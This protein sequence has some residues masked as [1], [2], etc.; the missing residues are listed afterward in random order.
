MADALGD[1]A[2]GN[3]AAGWSRRR[4][5]CDICHAT[6]VEVSRCMSSGKVY[7]RNN[8]ECKRA[9]GVNVNGTGEGAKKRPRGGGDSGSG[10]GGG[11]G[12]G[13]AS[14]N[15][16]GVTYDLEL[17]DVYQ[18]VGHRL[19]DADGLH[20][21]DARRGERLE[22]GSYDVEFYVRGIFKRA[23]AD[24]GLTD[25]LW[26][27]Q[28]EIQTL[29]RRDAATHERIT[30]LIIDYRAEMAMS[31]NALYEEE[32]EDEAPVGANAA[33]AAGA[34]ATGEAAA[35]D[36][37]DGAAVAAA[38][39]ASG[40]APH[41][42]L[43]RR[44]SQHIA[45]Q[46]C[47][48]SSIYNTFTNVSGSEFSIWLRHDSVNERRISASKEAAIDVQA[49]A[50]LDAAAAAAALLPAA[51]PTPAPAPPPTA[52]APPEESP[53]LP[54]SH[55]ADRCPVC[56]EGIS[57]WQCARCRQFA[58][59][60]CIATHAEAVRRK[61]CTCPLDYCTCKR[62]PSCPVCREP[63]PM[64]EGGVR[65]CGTPGCVLPDNHD[66]ACSTEAAS[67][68]RTR[69]GVVPLAGRSADEGGDHGGRAVAGSALG[70]GRPQE[71]CEAL[72]RRECAGLQ[73]AAS[74]DFV[75]AAPPRAHS[76][77]SAAVSLQPGT[78][79]HPPSRAARTGLHAQ[80]DG[81]LRRLLDGRDAQRRARAE[82]GGVQ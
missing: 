53:E 34:A 69:S 35:T 50:Y 13:S 64:E 57:T 29:A 75:R 66:G 82:D 63:L 19:H 1:E 4:G 43:V 71:E 46:G 3:E 45:A 36:A 59:H 58:H 72:A 67:R 70:A 42:E 17:F 33:V 21:L 12:G 9:A 11:G 49:A 10:V 16:A 81:P 27:P 22:R 74:A 14:G 61:E 51:A 32:A 68:T 24:P 41:D 48:L 26:R 7:C 65:C 80:A 40:A 73:K 25:T 76:E 8:R 2:L 54:A 6:D 20:Y 15:A 62:V 18:I 37:F 47:S 23:P 28:R 55:Q 30:Q 39:A 60:A 44:M 31:Y 77:R 5:H 56:L 52:A 38:A 79:A 78:H